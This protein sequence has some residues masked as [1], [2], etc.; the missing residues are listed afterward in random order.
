[1]TYFWPLDTDG[2]LRSEA[3]Y[4]SHAKRSTDESICSRLTWID[5]GGRAFRELSKAW[6]SGP[7][8]DRKGNASD[9]KTL[10][11]GAIDPRA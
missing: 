4:Q 10:F 2:R 9:P 1:M 8:P 3:T 7:C 5:R 11:S 6:L